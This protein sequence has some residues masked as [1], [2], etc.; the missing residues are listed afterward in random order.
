MTEG[1]CERKRESRRRRGQL[2][3][4]G[5]VLRRLRAGWRKAQAWPPVGGLA[6]GTILYATPAAAG[7]QRRGQRRASRD[8]GPSRH[9]PLSQA[10]RSGRHLN[11]CKAR[12]CAHA[13]AA[14]PPEWYA[15]CTACRA[16]SAAPAGR[17]LPSIGCRDPSSRLPH[18]SIHPQQPAKSSSRLRAGS[19]LGRGVHP[20]Q[21]PL[22]PPAWA[23]VW[24]M[25][26]VMAWRS[27][28]AWGTASATAL[29]TA[30]GG[31][32]HT[33]PAWVPAWPPRWGRA[34][35]LAWGQPRRSGRGRP[36]SPAAERVWEWVRQRG[37]VVSAVLQG[38]EGEKEPG[39]AALR[40]PRAAPASVQATVHVG[41]QRSF[42][43][44][45]QRRRRRARGAAACQRPR[46]R[47]AGGR[48]A[49]GAGGSP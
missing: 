19:G 34:W 25:A 10:P 20:M 16:S 5:G 22:S 33:A 30:G 23:T 46:G 32:W 38:G 41:G 21:P 2:A 1:P 15:R 27:T 8:V 29:A 44:G 3:C 35:A 14:N 47:A 31:A 13:H 17:C 28:P 4:V 42:T 12:M 26:W 45:T 36:W 11:S 37:G 43:Q 40:A 6:Y 49:R 24:V 7:L 39:A 48:A 9:T 18:P